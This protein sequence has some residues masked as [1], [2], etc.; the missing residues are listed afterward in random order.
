MKPV[1]LGQM[2]PFIQQGSEDGVGRELLIVKGALSQGEVLWGLFVKGEGGWSFLDQAFFGEGVSI[3]HFRCELREGDSLCT[4]AFNGE[5]GVQWTHFWTRNTPFS[6]GT[7]QGELL[8]REEDE[9]V[10]TKIGK[11]VPIQQ[12]KASV[13]WSDEVAGVFGVLIL[14]SK[15]HQYQITRTE[16]LNQQVDPSYTQNDLL[17]DAAW[18]AALANDLASHL[19]IS[20]KNLL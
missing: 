15:N 19:G 20:F 2:K 17:W 16:N 5:R 3:D 6:L 14:D 12:L 13:V 9:L 8:R 1:M 18:A 11:R 10:F 4:G 7:A